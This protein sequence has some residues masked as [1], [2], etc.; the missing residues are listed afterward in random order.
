MNMEQYN[1][2]ELRAFLQLYKVN[3]PG[4]EIVNRTKNLMREEMAKTFSA[5]TW[6]GGWLFLLV[7]VSL[8]MSMCIFYLLTVGTIL[9]LTLPPYMFVLIRHSILA[10][11][12]IGACFLTG[13]IIVFFFKQFESARAE[14]S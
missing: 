8:I 6:Q 14:I 1:E 10:F 7:S 13:L 4:A 3:A 5:P 2:N 11:T 9:R 12:G